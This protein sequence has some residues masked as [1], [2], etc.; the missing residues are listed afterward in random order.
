MLEAAL[1]LGRTN[2]L[3]VEGLCLRSYCAGSIITWGSSGTFASGRIILPSTS[4]TEISVRLIEQWTVVGNSLTG[5]VSTAGLSLTSNCGSV[6]K[7]GV[8]S[9]SSVLVLCS[10]GNDTISFALRPEVQHWY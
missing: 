2:S 7:V 6:D 3:V 8:A 9:V 4:L 1:C 10:T 5:S